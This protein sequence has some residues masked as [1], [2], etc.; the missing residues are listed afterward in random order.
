MK[1]LTLLLGVLASVTLACEKDEAKPFADLPEPVR[2]TID[3][4]NCMCDPK[5]GLFKWNDQLL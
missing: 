2:A 1:R 5:L 3:L 4:E